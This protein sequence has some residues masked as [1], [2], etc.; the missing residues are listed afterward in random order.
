MSQHVSLPTCPAC[1][2]DVVDRDGFSQLEGHL[3]NSESC[4][5]LLLERIEERAAALR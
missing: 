2:D 3:I 1:G 4:R 5:K